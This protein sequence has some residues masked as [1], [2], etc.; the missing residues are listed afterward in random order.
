MV[1]SVPG[2]HSSSVSRM[3]RL[4]FARVKIPMVPRV[5]DPRNNRP[6]RP[7]DF[8]LYLTAIKI[9]YV[10]QLSH[11]NIKLKEKKVKKSYLFGAADEYPA[12][13]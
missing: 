12:L 7:P 2:I 3:S 11:F 9:N 5:I 6:P 1:R 10:Y 4:F 8:S 13:E